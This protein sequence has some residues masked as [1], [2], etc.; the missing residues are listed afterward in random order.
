MGKERK[1]DLQDAAL[2]LQKIHSENLAY[3]EQTD[4]WRW[5]TGKF[6]KDVSTEKAKIDTMAVEALRFVG[7]DIN[8]AS[9]LDG[10]MR[11]A[12]S[13]MAREF[14][15]CT[16]VVN[17]AN[18][19]LAVDRRVDEFGKVTWELGSLVQHNPDDALTSCLPFN[20]VL[21]G[22]H[23]AISTFL[24]NAIPDPLARGCFVAHLG[25]SLLRDVS[26]HYSIVLYGPPRS[27]KSTLLSLA[28]LTA[29]FEYDQA[30]DWCPAGV[31][32][33]SSEGK[34]VRFARRGELITCVDEV[35]TAVLSGEEIFKQ[36]SA[37]GGAAAR[38]LYRDDERETRWLSKIIMA[39]NNS[40]KLKDTSGAIAARLIPVHVPL[41]R[42][43]GQRDLNLLEKLY[44]EVPAFAIRCI[45]AGLETLNRGYYERSV[46]QQAMTDEWS[47][48]GNSLRRFTND[49]CVLGADKKIP[50]GDLYSAYTKM[51]IEN[52]QTP[53]SSENFARELCDMG[54]GI[55]KSR[56]RAWSPVLKREVNGH[57][58]VGI[59]LK[60]ASDLAI[61]EIEEDRSTDY[62][63][64]VLSDAQIVARSEELIL[65][66]QYEKA[67]RL[68]LKMA[69][70]DLREETL[71]LMRE[72]N[73]ITT[74]IDGRY[75]QQYLREIISAA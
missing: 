2:A 20:A 10:T 40:L 19:T 7:V 32:E 71:A 66:Q 12:K 55:S 68:V 64:T 31:F 58:L 60:T 72:K 30:Q 47:L 3:D 54:L 62:T 5:W 18:G 39:T 1:A 35:P 38:G 11:L 48:A 63:P 69:D 67:R 27:G 6:W 75:A 16:G 51:L 56:G 17:F 61:E 74:E 45:R 65:A 28:R 70:K 37:H 23:P 24:E 21:D 14:K 50:Q 29:G 8:N 44:A 9:K 49:L 53:L 4:A 43:E 13:L 36:L 33:D 41:R 34:K 73:Y 57:R 59:A 52:G 46:A 42:V 22:T 15:S 25:L 26:M